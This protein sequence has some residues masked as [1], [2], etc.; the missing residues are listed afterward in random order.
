MDEN[1]QILSLQS[2]KQIYIPENIMQFTEKEKKVVENDFN[3]K[4]Y[5]N[6]YKRVCSTFESFFLFRI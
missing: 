3:V 2:V 6:E 4:F 5:R 1:E